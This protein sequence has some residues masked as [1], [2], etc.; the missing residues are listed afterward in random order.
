MT[1]GSSRLLELIE[2]S[3]EIAV[4]SFLNPHFCVRLN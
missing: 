3:A 1:S 4:I 2:D